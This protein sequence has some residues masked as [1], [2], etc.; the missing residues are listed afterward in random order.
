MLSSVEVEAVM[1][2][3]ASCCAAA[4]GWMTLPKSLNP[5][6]S[7]VAAWVGRFAMEAERRWGVGGKVLLYIG[8]AAVVIP[9]PLYFA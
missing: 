7:A 9:L 1:E 5:E 3:E 6:A 2:A 8:E 4:S